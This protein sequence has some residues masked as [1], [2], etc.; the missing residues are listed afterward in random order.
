MSRAREVTSGVVGGGRVRPPLSP[1]TRFLRLT[2]RNVVGY[3]RAW[4]ILVTG[5]LEPLLYLLSIGFGVGALVGDVEYGSGSI[6]YPVFVGA[7]MLATAAMNSAVFDTT[8]NFFLR[9][10][11]ARLYDA[12]LATPLEP[13]DVAV[14][15]VAW[16]LLRSALYSAAFLVTMALLGLVQSWWAVAAFPVTVLLGVAFA[17]AGLAAGT[18]IRS[19]LDFEYITLVV[20]PLFLLSATIFPLSEYPGWLAAIIRVTPLYQGVALNRACITGQVHIG[21]LAHVAYLLVM[22][23]VGVR[24][25]A[26]RIDRRLRR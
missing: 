23:V 8:L 20:T 3:A 10:K 22:V 6:P 4:P 16:S 9:L 12:V 2:E 13:R 5:L 17:S 25:A 19:F 21:L 15:E 11:H 24:V 18:F 7:G 1:R 26:R 14:G